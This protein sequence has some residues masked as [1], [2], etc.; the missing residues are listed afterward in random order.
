MLFYTYSLYKFIFTALAEQCAKADAHPGQES[1]KS[2]EDL[3]INPEALHLELIA[4]LMNFHKVSSS[5]KM[6]CNNTEFFH[7]G[8]VEIQEVNQLRGYQ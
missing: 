8:V 3:T 4:T 2:S 6:T 1:L 7:N 5:D